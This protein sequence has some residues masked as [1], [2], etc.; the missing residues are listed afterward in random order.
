[1]KEFENDYILRNKFIC[2]VHD[3]GIKTVI[4]TG[5]EFGGTASSFGWMKTVESVVTI[6]IEKRW[7]EL[8]SKVFF[9][10]G[11]SREKLPEAISMLWKS[12][13]FPVLF[14]LDA[15]PSVYMAVAP[16]R[17]ELNIIGAFYRDHPEAPAPW[18]AI[19]DCLVPGKFL[20]YDTY[21]D[22]HI[23]WDSFHKEITAIYPNGCRVSY[24]EEAVGA[25]RG[26][27]F[28]EPA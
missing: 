16:L 7:E 4:E 26:C 8:Q 28:V 17:D 23:S 9:L 14:F 12:Q 25:H 24:N 15:H 11:D 20:G 18:L 6:D 19:H 13:R 3:V 22:G 5:T 2:L 27:M 10:L 1:M 21:S